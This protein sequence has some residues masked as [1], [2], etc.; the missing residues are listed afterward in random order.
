MG[1]DKG[2]RDDMNVALL[3]PLYL[4]CTSYL[5]WLY[6]AWLERQDTYGTEL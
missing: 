4:L 2:D 1:G 5:P 3:P 6:Q